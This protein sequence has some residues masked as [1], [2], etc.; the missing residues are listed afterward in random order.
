[1]SSVVNAIDCARTL[2]ANLV[3]FSDV[4][5]SAWATWM[6][7]CRL[8]HAWNTAAKQ[9]TFIPPDSISEM[10][11]PAN[12]DVSDSTVG[13]LVLVMIR[14][15]P[16]VSL[17]LL[18]PLL[19]HRD[20]LS[21]VLYV[22][23]LPFTDMDLELNMHLERR[24]VFGL[25]QETA[26]GVT[27]QKS[28]PLIITDSFYLMGVYYTQQT[29]LLQRRI[30][31]ASPATRP[32]GMLVLPWTRSPKHIATDLSQRLST[33]DQVPHSSNPVTQLSD[34]ATWLVCSFLQ[35]HDACHLAC[36]C[37]QFFRCLHALPPV[38]IQTDSAPSLL[39]RSHLERFLFHP[40]AR[41][42]FNKLSLNG[43]DVSG[44]NASQMLM[45]VS[46]LH[47]LSELS[48]YF[49]GGHSDLILA[50]PNFAL[51]FGLTSLSF[52]YFDGVDDP[53][54]LHLP[55][56][57]LQQSELPELRTF[58]LHWQ[59]YTQRDASTEGRLAQIQS[60]FA[61]I[62]FSPL[63]RFR[64]TLWNLDLLLPADCRFT[65]A[66]LGIIRQLSMLREFNASYATVASLGRFAFYS[67]N[68]AQLLLLLDSDE[69]PS[70]LQLGLAA[71][72]LTAPLLPLLSSRLLRLTRL[73]FALIDPI[74]DGVAEVP[75]ED[76]AFLADRTDHLQELDLRPLW[77]SL[78][79]LSVAN[80]ARCT[81]LS[82]RMCD[83]TWSTRTETANTQ[84]CGEKPYVQHSLA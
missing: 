45:R 76:C 42:R 48:L 30:A 65:D 9:L 16:A 66:Q 50:S 7:L 13:S 6:S 23:V 10:D 46:G 41:F 20:W 38:P 49:S 71:T 8:N 47:Q 40:N 24:R 17:V 34:D 67:W 4:H 32:H 15:N 69:S 51:P 39:H 68:C 75:L 52:T 31:A 26:E 61:A 74:S 63:L 25:A 59:R 73:N 79:D 11:H 62:D 84:Y 54:R 2:L 56:S 14:L 28:C 1:M 18:K 21:H 72:C 64:Q 60:N 55:L 19:L 27:M 70:L 43:A 77:H 53:S 22:R 5:G 29:A 33:H 35:S 3:I 83:A 80:I 78:S 36:A 82:S 81:Q 58:Q 12:D 37:T 57:C 44:P